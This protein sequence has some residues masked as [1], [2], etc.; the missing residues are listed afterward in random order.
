MPPA[1]DVL[2]LFVT[3]VG[4]SAW[5]G[6]TIFMSFFVAPVISRRLSPG[7]AADISDVLQ[8]RLYWVSAASA[9]LMGIGGITALFYPSLRAP[10]ITFLVLTG[11]AVALSLYGGFVLVPRTTSL[12]DRLQSSA[13]SEWNFDVRERYDQATRIAVF[14][15]LLVLLLLLGAAAALAAILSNPPPKGG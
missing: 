2:A 6:A 3:V 9:I 15:N 7:Q 14:L 5:M 13:G 8:P 1:M 11:A 4:L 12:R 10:T